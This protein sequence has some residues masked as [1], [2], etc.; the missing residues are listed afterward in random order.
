MPSCTTKSYRETSKRGYKSKQPA[1][2]KY[3]V[4][5]KKESTCSCNCNCCTPASQN[6]STGSTDSSAGNR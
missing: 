3:G 5:C 6:T 2:R 1:V 4:S